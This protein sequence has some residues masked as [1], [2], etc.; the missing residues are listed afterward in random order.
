MNVRGEN[1]AEERVGN[2]EIKIKEMTNIEKKPDL[3]NKSITL[4]SRAQVQEGP[5]GLSE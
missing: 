1:T 2:A 4:S 3:K 5:T